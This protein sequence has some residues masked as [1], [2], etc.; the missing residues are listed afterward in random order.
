M[1]RQ[2]SRQRD[3]V[4]GKTIRGTWGDAPGSRGDTLRFTF[5]GKE[6]ETDFA[7][8]RSR[9][10]KWSSVSLFDDANGNGRFDRSETLLGKLKVNNRIVDRGVAPTGERALLNTGSGSLRMWY[11][12]DLLAKGRITPRALEVVNAELMA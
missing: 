5:D 6:F 9:G 12:N 10:K 11:D 7:I 2:T 8:K 1:A 3:S 4:T